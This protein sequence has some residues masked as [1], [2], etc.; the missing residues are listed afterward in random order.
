MVVTAHQSAWK[1]LEMRVDKAMVPDPQT[2]PSGEETDVTQAVGQVAQRG[3]SAETQPTRK[4]GGLSAVSVIVGLSLMLMVFPLILLMISNLMSPGLRMGGSASSAAFNSCLLSF[5]FMGL[6]GLVIASFVAL[7]PKPS[8]EKKGVMSVDEGAQQS[9]SAEA[10]QATASGGS[11]GASVMGW[12]RLW[13]PM[14]VYPP[15]PV[16]K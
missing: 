2:I 5:I 14:N 12:A 10:Q 3:D 7:L 15:R 8:S 1:G 16:K 4:S 13:P 11:S 6:V 9:D